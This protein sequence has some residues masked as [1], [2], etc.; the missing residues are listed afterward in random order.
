MHFV[1]FKTAM[2]ISY[3]QKCY[4]IYNKKEAKGRETRTTKG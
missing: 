4:F 3:T 1:D 2:L